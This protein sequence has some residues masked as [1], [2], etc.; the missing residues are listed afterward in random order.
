MKHRGIAIA[1]ALALML[2]GCGIVSNRYVDVRKHTD[3]YSLPEKAEAQTVETR[4]ELENAMLTLIHSGVKEAELNAT[5]YPGDFVAD[6][7]E[8]QEDILSTDP[9][10]AYMVESISKRITAVEPYYKLNLLFCYRRTPMDA[11]NAQTVSASGRSVEDIVAEAMERCEEKLLLRFDDYHATDFNK[12]AEEYFE[13][14]LLRVMAKPI[15]TAKSYPSSGSARLMELSFTYVGLA[16][17]PTL[18]GM[19]SSVDTIMDSAEGYVKGTVTEMEKAMLLYSFLSE[20]FDYKVEPSTTPAYDMLFSGIADSRTFSAVY[21]AMCE[22]AGLECTEVHGS[23]D[24]EP[25]DWVI[26]ELGAGTWHVDPLSDEQAGRRTLQFLTDSQ[27]VG[28]EWEEDYPVCFG[29]V[30]LPPVQETIVTET[31][32]NIPESPEEAPVSPEPPDIPP[33]EKENEGEA[34]ITS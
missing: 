24:G 12:I 13:N 5:N 18:E 4:Q 19:R 8:V 23:K 2:S 25:Y 6:F 21:Y 9:E 29:Y 32:E 14:N 20:R 22:R 27:M 15:I 16:G 31:T 10:S 1:L 11:E 34:Q 26:L 17:K 30:E 28:Y 7:A 33:Q 3:T